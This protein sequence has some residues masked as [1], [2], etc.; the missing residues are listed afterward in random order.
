MKLIWC[1]ETK[2]GF[3]KIKVSNGEIVD[4]Y[5]ILM[6][7]LDHATDKKQIKNIKR[8]YKY[9][10]NRIKKIKFDD[11]LMYKLYFI[12]R[13]LW[14]VEDTLRVLENN[15]DF[16]DKFIVNARSVY[17]LNDKRAKIKKA[18]NS[19]TYSKFVEEKIL[20]NYKEEKKNESY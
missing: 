2:D 16:S 12:N 8:E 5:T 4:K 17:H 11:E 10:K 19:D 7:K 9:L 18:I 15:K 13:E 1:I 3:M 6:I 20:P 14:C